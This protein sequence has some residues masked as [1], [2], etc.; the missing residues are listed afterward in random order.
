MSSSRRSSDVS[1]LES[2]SD[3][4]RASDLSDDSDEGAS[5]TSFIASRV[6]LSVAATILLWAT[7]L[8]VINAWIYS[9]IPMPGLLDTYDKVYLF[10]NKTQDE[11][12]DYASCVDEELVRCNRSLDLDIDIV[13][14]GI[15]DGAD[16]VLEI[17]ER[18]REKVAIAQ[19]YSRNC[20]RMYTD[21]LSALIAWQ[22][23]QPFDADPEAAFTPECTRDERDYLMVRAAAAAMPLARFVSSL[24]STPRAHPRRRKQLAWSTTP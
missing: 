18:N 3:A 20:S 21:S 12:R 24:L 8:S 16:G 14:N 22:N 1:S 9:I 17:L 5:R 13:L 7:S 10:V 15:G 19:S 6:V 11:E 2:I 23:E 4:S